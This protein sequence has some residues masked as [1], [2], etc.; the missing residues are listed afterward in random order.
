MINQKHFIQQFELIFQEVYYLFI[1]GY[2]NKSLHFDYIDQL[3]TE[4]SSC[5]FYK[6]H[7]MLIYI[8][9]LDLYQ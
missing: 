1:V 5:L 7:W 6:L 9:T 8:G 2:I 3:A 4:R